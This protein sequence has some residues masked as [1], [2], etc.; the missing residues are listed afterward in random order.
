MFDTGWTGAGAAATL[1][2][3]TESYR[4]MRAKV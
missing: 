2:K 3:G 1:V 4:S